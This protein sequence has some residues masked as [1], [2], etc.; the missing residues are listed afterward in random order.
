MHT[1]IFITCVCVV[2]GIVCFLDAIQFFYNLFIF[3]LYECC[4][5]WYDSHKEYEVLFV[6]GKRYTIFLFSCFIFFD[7]PLHN[8]HTFLQATNCHQL[9]GLANLRPQQ[10]STV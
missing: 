9:F 1:Q 6:D 5:V 10:N 3:F 4:L 8:Q 2:Q 7:K